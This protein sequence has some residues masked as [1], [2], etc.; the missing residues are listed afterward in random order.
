[1][2]TLD[3][4]KTTLDLSKRIPD[5]QGREDVFVLPARALRILPGHDA[6]HWTV[7]VGC[8][9][10]GRNHRHYWRSP[11]QALIPQR[12]AHCW[13]RYGGFT[14]EYQIDAADA[15]RAHGGYEVQS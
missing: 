5:S 15:E 1:M 9:W 6:D 12:V 4:N 2:R 11:G 10:C 14:P 13:P 7:I 8:P 3:H